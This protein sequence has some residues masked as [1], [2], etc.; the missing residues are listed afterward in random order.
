VSSSGEVNDI[1]DKGGYSYPPPATAS[2]SENG[3][4]DVGEDIRLSWFSSGG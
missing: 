4:R 2:S 3:G 1:G